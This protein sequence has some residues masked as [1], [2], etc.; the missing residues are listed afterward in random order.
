MSEGVPL[1]LS[2][3]SVAVL[4]TREKDR[5][6]HRWVHHWNVTGYSTGKSTWIRT[7]RDAGHLTGNITR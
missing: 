4:V 6:T 5:T 7:R 1:A 3:K 2:L